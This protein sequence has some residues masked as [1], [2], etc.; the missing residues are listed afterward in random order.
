MG[1]AERP[2]AV[3]VGVEQP[4][5]VAG[6]FLVEP[7]YSLKSGREGMGLPSLYGFVKQSGGYIFV[8]SRPGE[9]TTFRIYFPCIASAADPGAGDV[10]PAAGMTEAG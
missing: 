6:E 7:F 2:L 10:S 8:D 3:G 9:G 5:V 1:V 4:G